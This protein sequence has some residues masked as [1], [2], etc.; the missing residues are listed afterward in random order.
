MTMRILLITQFFP[1]EV[2]A[3]QNRLSALV[4]ACHQENHEITVLTAM[5][6]YPSG[7]VFPGYRGC[8]W[9]RE[10]VG[11]VTV[12]RSWILALGNGRLARLLSFGT[13]LLSALVVGLFMTPPVDLVLWESP[14]LFLGISVFVLSKL[15]RAA[16]VT[17]VADLWPASFVALGELKDGMAVY[18]MEKLELF[19]YSR[20]IGISGQTKGIVA[21]I[22]SRIGGIPITH[23]GNGA[24]A[25]ATDDI[26]IPIRRGEWGIQPGRFVVGYAG[27]FGISQGLGLILRAAAALPDV[28]FV[29][30]GD[31]PCR[32]AL[33]NQS[34]ELTLANLI[35]VPRQPQ[36]GMAS[37]WASFDCT[38]ICLRDVPLFRGAVPS[39]LFEAMAA[40]V[41]I[42]LAI[43]GEAAQIV[44]EEDIGLVIS[45]E[46]EGELTAAIIMMRSD[47]SMRQAFAEHGRRAVRERYDRKTLIRD[48]VRWLQARVEAAQ[49]T[50]QRPR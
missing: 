28:T 26:A 10:T 41:P 30:V 35:W 34:E 33:K 48:Y 44:R 23:W 42:V 24:D 4:N 38:L 6:H 39:K 40:G 21:D 12:I 20:S 32:Q 19:L 29:L 11:S 2:G 49:T 8:F 50:P 25:H 45:P 22:S 7:R 17:N 15:K 9:R 43:A 1:P 16:L 13:F 3:T 37:V 46:N 36:D 5:P 27:L 18:L 14:P 31:G 47:A